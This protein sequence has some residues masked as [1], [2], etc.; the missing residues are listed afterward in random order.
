MS[1]NVENVPSDMCS[2]RRLIIQRIGVVWLKSSLTAWK[3][4]AS[5]AIPNAAI[6]FS[7]QTA[8]MQA[9]LNLSSAHMSESKLS[10]I[11]AHIM[12]IYRCEHLRPG[13]AKWYKILAS[14]RIAKT[15]LFKYI[16]N[17]TTKNWNFLDKNSDIFHIQS[18]LNT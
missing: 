13:M 9:D 8:R 14:A 10:D 16:E 11:E 4:F 1:H 5:L 7:D 17:F 3:N 2:Q 15:R 12:F 6:E 18:L